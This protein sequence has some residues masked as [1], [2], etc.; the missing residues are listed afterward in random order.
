MSTAGKKSS[1]PGAGIEIRH[2]H[3][4]AEFARC[5]E[6]EREVWGGADLDQVPSTIFVVAH[7]TGGQV[8]GAYEREDGG[9]MIGFTLARKSVV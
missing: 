7:E 2:C 3:Q 6:L 4:L 1:E 9:R 8:L 5:M